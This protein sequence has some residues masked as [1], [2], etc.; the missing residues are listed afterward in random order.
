VRLV[1][2][3]VGFGGV[4]LLVGAQPAGDLVAAAAVVGSALCYAV[5]ALYAGRRLAHASPL[6]TAIGALGWAAVALAPFAAV[7]HPTAFPSWEVTGALLGLAVGGT[8]VAYVLYYAI[9]AGAGASY[10]ILVTY[11]TPAIALLYGASLLDEPVTATAVGGL[12]LVLT[13]VA[14]GTEAVRPLRRRTPVASAP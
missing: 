9:L 14:L 3:L 8:G 1:G 13:G 7:E 6:V 2:F 12:A 10:A 11:L 4:A 5:S